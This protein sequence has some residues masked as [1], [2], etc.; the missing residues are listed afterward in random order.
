MDHPWETLAIFIV[1][2]DINIYGHRNSYDVL[3]K[4]K[5][6]IRLFSASLI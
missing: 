5:T 6:V 2:I 1:V 3:T 4:N